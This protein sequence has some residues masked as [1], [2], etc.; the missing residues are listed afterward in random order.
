MIAVVLLVVVGVGG[1]R[2]GAQDDP[3]AV[4]V[5]DL[6][7]RLS[8]VEGRLAVAE[9]GSVPASRRLGPDGAI[10][11]LPATMEEM[12]AN[13]AELTDSSLVAGSEDRLRLVCLSYDPLYSLRRSLSP[14]VAETIA[15]GL[16]GF[17]C[18]R[19]PGPVASS[20]EATATRVRA[21]LP[22][23]GGLIP[24]REPRS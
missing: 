7:A 6:E 22:V 21:P 24:T 17:E 18:G 16:V 15:L 8:E 9:A 23:T 20:G 2:A 3:L 10:L 11:G 1:Y 14:W 4:R 19:V 5:R 12:I 13:P